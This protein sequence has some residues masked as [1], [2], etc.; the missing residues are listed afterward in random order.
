MICVL[1]HFNLHLIFFP[2]I[3]NFQINLTRERSGPLF[4]YFKPNNMPEFDSLKTNTVS[5]EV[6]TSWDP[7][8]ARNAVPVKLNL[9]MII[10]KS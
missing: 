2:K 1:K 7:C 5:A 8:Y 10:S 3:L 9:F 6:S 4:N